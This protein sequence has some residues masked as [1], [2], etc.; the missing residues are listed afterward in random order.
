MNAAPIGLDDSGRVVH[1]ILVGT[2]ACG[3]LGSRCVFDFDRRNY[4]AK[5]EPT[6]EPASTLASIWDGISKVLA[7]GVGSAIGLALAFGI[8]WLKSRFTQKT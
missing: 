6:L 8:H 4:P 2:T 1:L 7:L 3:W 5:G